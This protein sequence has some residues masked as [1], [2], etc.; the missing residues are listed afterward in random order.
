MN[1]SGCTLFLSTEQAQFG[2][3]GRILVEVVEGVG[4]RPGSATEWTV[5]LF[6]IVPTAMQYSLP[7]DLYWRYSASPTLS[8]VP[9]NQCPYCIYPEHCPYKPVSLLSDKPPLGPNKQRDVSA[10]RLIAGRCDAFC[11]VSMGSQEH[12]TLAVQATSEA[13]WN[14]TM[15]FLVKDLKEDVL[16]ITVFDRGHFSPNGGNVRSVEKEIPVK[17]RMEEEEILVKRRMEEEIPVKRRGGSRKGR[18]WRG[19]SKQSRLETIHDETLRQ[20]G[21]E[22]SKITWRQALHLSVTERGADRH[23]ATVVSSR[24]RVVLCRN[25]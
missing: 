19:C 15:Q 21:D 23:S 24:A 10:F 9:T 14:A 6:S 8:T 7:T 1:Y 17:R 2:A 20:D 16:C 3:C 11:E 12:R 22:S 4:L 5:L 18:H 13:R 25:D